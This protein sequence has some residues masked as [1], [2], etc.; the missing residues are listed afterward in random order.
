MSWYIGVS[1]FFGGVFVV[2]AMPHLIAGIS[3]R[4]LQTPF[5]SPPF[6]G[7]SSPVVN[8]VWGLL[9]LVLAYVL[10]VL[11]GDFQLGEP[12]DAALSFLGF[13]LMALQCARSFGRLQVRQQQ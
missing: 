9:N 8:V 4:P 7:L 13:S 1:F 11:V 5:A 6:Q 12:L 10:L 3:G 2:N